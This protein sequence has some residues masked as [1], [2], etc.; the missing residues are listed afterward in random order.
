MQVQNLK[1]LAVSVE[2][3]ICLQR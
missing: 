2:A 1:M 3:N